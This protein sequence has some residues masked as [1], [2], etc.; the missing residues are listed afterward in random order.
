MTATQHSEEFLNTEQKRIR[1]LELVIG[2]LMDKKNRSAQLQVETIVWH[3]QKE[4][5]D[6]YEE[7]VEYT[8]CMLRSYK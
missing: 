2:E 8:K 7:I 4:V 1:A 3:L 6:V 5:D